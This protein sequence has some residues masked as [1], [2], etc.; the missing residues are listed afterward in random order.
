MTNVFQCLCYCY[1]AVLSGAGRF[2]AHRRRRGA[3][4]I[5]AAARITIII[6]QFQRVMSVNR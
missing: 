5:V 2:G 1:V 4:H 6:K 3:G